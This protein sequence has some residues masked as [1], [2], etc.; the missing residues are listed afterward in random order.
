MDNDMTAALVIRLSELEQE[1]KVLRQ[2]NHALMNRLLDMIEYF[3]KPIVLT[4][5][6]A[7]DDK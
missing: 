2:E 6:E 7:G 5:M 3:S 4:N 1:I